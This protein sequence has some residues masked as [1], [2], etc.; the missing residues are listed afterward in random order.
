M[1]RFGLSAK[2]NSLLF[3]KF[4]SPSA[5][6]DVILS[7]MQDLLSQSSDGSQARLTLPV[8]SDPQSGEVARDLVDQAIRQGSISAEQNEQGCVTDWKELNKIYKLG[9]PSDLLSAP[10]SA[11]K[12]QALTKY[13]DICCTSVAMKLVAT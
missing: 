3:V 5:S 12:T 10:S 2:S 9:I 11:S 8:A 13:E 7:L 1:K 4:S 6:S